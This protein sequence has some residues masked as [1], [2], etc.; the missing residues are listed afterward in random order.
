MSQPVDLI[1]PLVVLLGVACAV[2]FVLTR[3]RLPPVVGYLCS[4]V[5]LG[6]HV[7][8]LIRKSD[9]VS[10][11]AEIGVMLLMFTLGLEFDTRYF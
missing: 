11:L 10:T 3:L 4:G 8:G 5:L 6:P 9:A 2:L 1:G 7:L